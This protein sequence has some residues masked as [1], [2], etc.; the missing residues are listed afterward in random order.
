MVVE[1]GVG[2]DLEPVGGTLLNVGAK[3]ITVEIRPYRDTVLI[4]VSAR[5]VVVRAVA[6]ARDRELVVLQQRRIVIYGIEPVH[7]RL[8][9]QVVVLARGEAYLLLVL[10]TLGRVHQVPVVLRQLRE[11]ELHAVGDAGLR[12][13]TSA[14]GRDDD[15][16]VRGAGAVDRCRRGV[17]EHRDRLDIGGVDGVEVGTRDCGAVEDIEGSRSRVDR[18][19][20]SDAER[21]RHTR[22]T[23]AGQYRQAGD[24]SLQRLIERRRGGV[25]DLLGLD[26][27]DRSGNGAL[28]AHAVG[29]DHDILKGF[30]FG[31]ELDIVFD[32]CGSIRDGVLHLLVSHI[33][34][35]QHIAGLDIYGV[36]PVEERTY[37]VVVTRNHMRPDQRIL[38][39]RGCYDTAYRDCSAALRQRRQREHQQYDVHE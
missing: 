19:C 6:R 17:L 38:V 21:G 29:Y 5:D 12:G 4:V 26:R 11:S 10:D 32:A 37:A 22:F 28:L 20:A 2:T 8:A 13:H 39:L 34:I 7:I 35:G 1:H 24:L 15:H 31:L 3:R 30:R 36:R 25:L 33:I 16:A 27:R 9:Q 14:L 18:V 23:R